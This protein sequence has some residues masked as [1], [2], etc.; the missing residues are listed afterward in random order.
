[1][2][3]VI[4]IANQKGGVGKTTTAVNLAACLADLGRRVLLIDLDPQAN[5]TSGLLKSLEQRE[6][7]D[8]IYHALSGDCEIKDAAVPARPEGL[9]IVPS[10]TDLAGAEIELLDLPK[11]EYRLKEALGSAPK[12]Y[13]YVFID[14]PPSL[15]I[16]T[17]NALSACERVLIPMQCEYYALEGLGRLLKT[18]GLVRERLNSALKMEGIILTMYDAR[19]NLSRQVRDEV[20]KHFADKV[21]KTVI[22]RNVRL[23]EAPSHGLPIILYDLHCPGA[24][25]YMALADE[26][27][28]RDGLMKSA[29]AAHGA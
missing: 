23:G 13:D 9:W 2:G 28:M 7:K 26:M 8:T 24:S 27:L 4:S 5:A 11:R 19:N 14:C 16:L 22:P 10:D 12:E 17:L 21:F 15:S 6:D 18:L 25:A 1:M 20:I 3:R 29:G